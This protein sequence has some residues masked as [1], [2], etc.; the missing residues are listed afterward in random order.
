MPCDFGNLVVNIGDMLQEASGGYF[1]STS[2]RVVNPEG[3]DHNRSR[4]SIPLFLH[5]RPE[6]V[7]SQRHTAGSYLQE[8]LAELRQVEEE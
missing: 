7:L 2:H 8:R 4:V 6:V 3:A 1:P 5:P